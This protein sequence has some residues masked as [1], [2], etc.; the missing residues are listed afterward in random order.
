VMGCSDD[1]ETHTNTYPADAGRDVESVDAGPDAEEDA[2]KNCEC[3]NNNGE[4]LERQYLIGDDGSKVELS[5]WHDIQLDLNCSYEFLPNRQTYCVPPHEVTNTYLDSECKTPVYVKTGQKDI[6]VEDHCFQ[7]PSY[8]RFGYA[9]NINTC[10]TAVFEDFKIHKVN[11]DK[12]L[13][14]RSFFYEKS[15][16]GLCA[17]VDLSFDPSKDAILWEVSPVGGLDKFVRVVNSVDL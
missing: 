9:N 1:G 10:G 5:L 7:L 15:S 14:R 13:D 11:A 2:G 6:T 3:S 16:N 12:I 17:V 4:R 8:V